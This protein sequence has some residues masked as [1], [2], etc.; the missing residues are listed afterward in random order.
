MPFTSRSQTLQDKTVTDLERPPFIT[1]YSSHFTPR[2]L[3]D[4]LQPPPGVQRPVLCF[5][6]DKSLASRLVRARLKTSKPPR[7]QDRIV[8]LTTPYFKSHSKPCTAPGCLC[9][10]HMSGRERIQTPHGPYLTPTN[11]S[12][13]SRGLIYLLECKLCPTH[14][15]YVGQTSRTLKER[16]AGHRAAFRTGKNMPI[17]VHL[18]RRNHTFTSL[19]AT[20]L[21]VLPDPTEDDLLSAESRWMEL[22]NSKLPHGLNSKF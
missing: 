12:C 22:L 18:R 19:A 16:L 4:A 14:N 11:T 7:N 8:I 5:R 2:Q 21:Q 1:L 10:P 6:K 9:C 15:L 20:V 17:Y 3:S 13:S